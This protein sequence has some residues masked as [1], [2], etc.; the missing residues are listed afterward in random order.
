MLQKCRKMLKNEKG[1][2]LIELLAVVVILGIIAAIAIPSIG[3]IIE[4]SRNEAHSATALQVMSGAR[5]AIANGDIQPSANTTDKEHAL[6]TFATYVEKIDSK[7]TA[8]K[9]ITT[10]GK[11]TGASLT[12]DGS[13]K[14][15]DE[16]GEIVPPAGG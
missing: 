4:K 2:T 8:V 6:D 7:Y 1:L 3:N 13:A 12:Y 14:V 9:V 16:N 10:N 5:L 15:F 11:V